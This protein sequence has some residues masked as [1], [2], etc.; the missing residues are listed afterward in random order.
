MLYIRF[1]PNYLN[2]EQKHVNPL[3]AGKQRLVLEHIAS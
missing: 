1:Q 3:V 2:R